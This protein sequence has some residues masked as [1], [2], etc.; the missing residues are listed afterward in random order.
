MRSSCISFV[1]KN[2]PTG[3]HA[4][5]ETIAMNDLSARAR[6]AVLFAAVT[7]T[8]LVAVGSFV[9]SFNGLRDLAATYGVPA[10]LAWVFP[11][12][13]DGTIISAS[14]AVVVIPRSVYGWSVLAGAALISITGNGVHALQ[15][16]PIGIAIATVPPV[17]LLATTH[18]LVK[19]SQ[20]PRPV[21]VL[22]VAQDSRPVWLAR[23]YD[24]DAP[25]LAKSWYDN[26]ADMDIAM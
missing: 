14:L 17:L 6:R 10:S 8:V 26:H 21:P 7:L 1:S 13:V 24:A 2:V 22:A 5:K 20:A 11:L 15:W 4:S 19:L 12:T 16:G 25:N 3:T 18:V 9:L 23:G